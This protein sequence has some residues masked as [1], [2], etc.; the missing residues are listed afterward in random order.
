MSPQNV[1]KLV[2]EFKSGV[3]AWYITHKELVAFDCL[4]REEMSRT[5]AIEVNLP[6]RLEPRLFTLEQEVVEPG[7]AFARMEGDSKSL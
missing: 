7:G 1:D 4:P 6:D 3:L 2:V 5:I